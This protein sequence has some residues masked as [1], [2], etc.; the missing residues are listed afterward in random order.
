MKPSEMPKIKKT[1]LVGSTG[2]VGQNLLASYDFDTAVHSTNVSEAF[3]DEYSLVVYAGVTGTKYLA[4]RFPEKDL[5]VIDSALGNLQQI[6][7]EKI[8][9]I[10]TVDVYEHPF[11]KDEDNPVDDMQASAYGRHR[12]FLEKAVRNEYPH[13]LFVRLPAIYGI[14]LKKNFV[15][16]MIHA[17]P[18]RLEAQRYQE[19]AEESSLIKENYIEAENGFYALRDDASLESLDAWFSNSSFNALSF[20]DSRSTYQFYDLSC[21]WGHIQQAL[22]QNL[23]V[24]NIATPPISAGEAY[25]FIFDNAWTNH[26]ASPVVQYDIKSKYFSNERGFSGY[27]QS[28]E[29]ALSRLKRFVTA[30]MAASS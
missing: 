6:K 30:Q 22:A 26:L 8:V 9:L 13:A 5:Q 11:G 10:S 25:Q 15:Y 16:D 4:N 20:T 29:E 3:I 12:A 19:F 7:A 1:L 28:K 14:G 18:S 24:L 21:L 27:S 17:S 2:L 23:H